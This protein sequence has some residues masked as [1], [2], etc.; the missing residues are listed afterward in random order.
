MFLLLLGIV[1]RSVEL[2]SVGTDVLT[3]GLVIPAFSQGNC[4]G[5]ASGLCVSVDSTHDP[6]RVSAQQRIVQKYVGCL[7][8]I[9]E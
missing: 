3:V 7:A 8:L 5:I 1:P 2:F 9:F 6:F 4:Q